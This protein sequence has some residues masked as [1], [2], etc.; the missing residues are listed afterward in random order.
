MI[1]METTIMAPVAFTQKAIAEIKRLLQE[2]SVGSNKI[3]RV[4]V[5]GGGCSGLS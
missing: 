1:N 4:G 2:E 3:L 5:K